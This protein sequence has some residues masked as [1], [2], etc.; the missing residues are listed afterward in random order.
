MNVKNLR[1]FRRHITA[2]NIVASVASGVYAAAFYMSFTAQTDLAMRFAVPGDQ[3]FVLPMVVDGLAIAANFGA[4]SL[5]RR[6]WQGYAW[7]ALAL[8]TVTSIATNGIHAWTVMPNPIAVGI[9]VIPPIFAF[10]VGHLAIGLFREGRSRGAV[11]EVEEILAT[12]DTTEA[13]VAPAPAVEEVDTVEIPVVEPIVE[14]PI[15]IATVVEDEAP[16]AWSFADFDITPE[17]AVEARKEL[18]TA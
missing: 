1:G 11:Q 15:V 12:V 5:R 18:I 3:A 16:A 9:A 2:P 10:I 13:T 17:P 6:V 14:E 8:A 4:A 7:F